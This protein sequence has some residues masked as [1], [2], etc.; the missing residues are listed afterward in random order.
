MTRCKVGD[1]AYLAR[2][3]LAENVGLVVEVVRGDSIRCRDESIEQW[4]WICVTRSPVASIDRT[5]GALQPG[6]TGELSIPDSNLR[7]ISGV[8]IDDEVPEEREW[9]IETPIATNIGVSAQG[10][11]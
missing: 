9:S 7:P 1:L 3:E 6:W 2:A 10:W 8:P 4:R 5:T 11:M